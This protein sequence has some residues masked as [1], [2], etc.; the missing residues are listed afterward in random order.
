MFSF[1]RFLLETNTFTHED[2]DYDLT[3]L[4]NL[5]KSVAVKNTPVSDL[6]WIFKY[7]DPKKDHPE[8]VKTAD[9]KV[10]IL[11]TKDQGQ[12]VVLD[13]LHRLA[14]AVKEKIKELPSKMVTAEMLKKCLIGPV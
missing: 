3:T 12:L 1:K 2:N 6:T 14:K 4:N 8:R 7:D 13:G 9:I 5:V 10:P 11:V